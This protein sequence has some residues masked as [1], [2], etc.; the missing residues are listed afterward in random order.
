MAYLDSDDE[1]LRL[2]GC[3]ARSLAETRGVPFLH[4]VESGLLLSALATDPPVVVTA[5]ASVIDD[6]TCRER[7]RH[8]A[9]VCWIDVP[10]SVLVE[11][12]GFGQ[13]R[14][15]MSEDEIEHTLIR[16][17]PLFADISA[18]HL[19]GCLPVDDLVE[20]VE[21]IIHSRTTTP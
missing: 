17:L 3:D 19:D 12:I 15:P 14:R 8:D 16:R 7:L 2:Y 5:A 20:Q 10:A 4:G 18:I 11:R 9:L 1:I 13:H 21:N 6:V